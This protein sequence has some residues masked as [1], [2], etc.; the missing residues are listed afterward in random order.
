MMSI[1]EG[2]ESESDTSSTRG[3]MVR[4]GEG[5]RWG[6]WRDVGRAVSLSLSP[7]LAPSHVCSRRGRH[8]V[9]C[10]KA[11]TRRQGGESVLL[12]GGRGRQVR[13]DGKAG[14]SVDSHGACGVHERRERFVWCCWGSA[15]LACTDQGGA[16]SVETWSLWS[17]LPFAREH[18]AFHHLTARRHHLLLLPESPPA[19][20]PT[21]AADPPRAAHMHTTRGY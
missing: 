2:S 7:S 17:S 20:T 3:F 15:R 1:S 6:R 19:A 16:A 9:G 10:K 18:L 5:W 13:R 21:T 11:V 4:G 8:G 14:R 12:E